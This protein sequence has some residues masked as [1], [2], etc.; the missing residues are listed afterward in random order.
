VRVAVA[1]AIAIAITIAITII[2]QP[3]TVG[4]VMCDP[5]ACARDPPTFRADYALA[6]NV[7]I[8]KEERVATR[9]GRLF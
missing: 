1:V 7:R 3:G 2:V 6:V 5:L 4:L 8:G 9:G